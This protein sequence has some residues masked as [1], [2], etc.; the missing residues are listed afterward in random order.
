LRA[1]LYSLG[2]HALTARDTVLPE[3]SIEE[4]REFSDLASVHYWDTA[5]R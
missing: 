5:I 4:G 2:R 3:P 1:S